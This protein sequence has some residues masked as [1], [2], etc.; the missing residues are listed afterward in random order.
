MSENKS[1]SSLAPLPLNIPTQSPTSKTTRV[2][3]SKTQRARS[4]SRNTLTKYSYIPKSTHYSLIGVNTF[5]NDAPH[6]TIPSSRRDPQSFTE[7]CQV[8]G[9]G[10]YEPFE[11][12]KPFTSRPVPTSQF[13]SM[14]LDRGPFNQ[15]DSSTLTSNIG[16]I[17]KREFPESKPAY[18]GVRTK[19][20]FYDIIETPGPSYFTPPHDTRLPHRIL[21]S[22]R[23]YCTKD[24]PEKTDPIGLGT[25][26]VKYNL[27]TKRE[28][29][30]DIS[31]A[32]DRYNWMTHE[33]SLGPGSYSPVD[34]KKNEPQWSIGQKSRPGKKGK[35]EYKVFYEKIRENESKNLPKDLIVVDQ[36]I[37]HLELLKDPKACRSYVVNH[38]QL[39]NI[40]H[41]ILELVLKSKPDNPVDFIRE[42]FKDIDNKEYD[43]M[44]QASRIEGIKKELGIEISDSSEETEAETETE[45][46]NK[47]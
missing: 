29:G 44:Y 26:N 23:E 35:F 14:S 5:G 12:I 32:Y 18:I 38:P 20:D 33:N 25:Y 42:Y 41:D 39:R 6:F 9:P 24:P 27:L 15:N 36:I 16:F 17:N 45:T 28:P 46:E 11:K 19:H 4:V 7:Q 10:S 22:G 2:V 1:K 8:P 43:G 13:R 34:V 47:K 30:Y 21:S 3:G 31:G 37:I 40:V